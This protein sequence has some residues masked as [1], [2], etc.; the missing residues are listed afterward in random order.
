MMRFSMKT[1]SLCMRTSSSFEVESRLLRL[2]YA[3]SGG[4]EP[5]KYEPGFY[6]SVLRAHRHGT[7]QRSH[8]VTVDRTCR[9]TLVV[10]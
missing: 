2:A 4:E 6:T 8:L 9:R 3:E 5:R 10:S 1:H 7:S